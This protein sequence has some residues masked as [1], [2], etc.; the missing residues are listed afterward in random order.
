VAGSCLPHSGVLCVRHWLLRGKQP[1]HT[2]KQAY[3]P[4]G[5]SVNQAPS[6]V[7]ILQSFH[8]SS[9]FVRSNRDKTRKFSIHQLHC[10]SFDEHTST[11]FRNYHCNI[12]SS[13]VRS[14]ICLKFE[15]I[16]HIIHCFVKTSS[17]RYASFVTSAGRGRSSHQLS[18]PL[19]TTEHDL[20]D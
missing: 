14:V 19:L 13:I 12:N 4:P 17:R 5:P 15:A 18:V 8:S 3:A 6:A 20:V 9:C 16:L 7:A 2:E 11:F 1:R 10:F